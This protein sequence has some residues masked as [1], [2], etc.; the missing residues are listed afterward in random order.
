MAQIISLLLLAFAVSIDSF[1][2]GLTYGLRKMKFPVKS[3]AVIAL[4]S[5]AVLMV[6]MLIGHFL[7]SFFSPEL[8]EMLGGMV[9]IVL[10]GWVL[11]Q[12]FREDQSELDCH[13]KIILNFEIKSLGIVINILRKPMSADF[14]QSGTINGM[15]A[16]MLGLALSLDAFGAGIG[17]ALLGFSPGY[18]ALTVAFM[19]SLFVYAGMRMG[20]YF[21]ESSWL[22]KFSFVPGILLIVIGLLKL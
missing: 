20:S 21:S 13:E 8:A 9:L 7:E 10:G 22:Q 5:A 14:D 18:L 12:F 4:C 19:S 15:E 6:A 3:I 2:V 11:F 16:V 1:S 17:A